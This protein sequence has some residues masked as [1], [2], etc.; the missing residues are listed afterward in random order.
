MTQPLADNPPR[1]LIVADNASLKFG[2]E[3]TKPYLFFKFFRQRGMDVRLLVH[4]RC[5]DELLA[6]LEVEGVPAGPI[7]SVAEVFA[8][9]QVIARGMRVDLPAAAAVG[10]TLPSVR[11]PIVMDGEPLVAGRPSPRLGEHTGEVFDDPAWTGGR[12]AG[13]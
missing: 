1:V 9:P 11:L 8:D 3:A 13:A 12:E 10:G 5:R 7:N 4:G 6:A 2:G